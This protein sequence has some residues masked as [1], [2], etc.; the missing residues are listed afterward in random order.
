MSTSAD[1]AGGAAIQTVRIQRRGGLAGLP[2]SVELHYAALS[3]TQRAA[4][5]KVAA[6]GATRGSPAPSAGADRF[7]FRVELVHASG[8][9]RVID[10]PEDAMPASLAGLAKPALP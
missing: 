1:A 8:D 7:S 5:D 2:A 4:V 3:V 9:T 10:M 6:A